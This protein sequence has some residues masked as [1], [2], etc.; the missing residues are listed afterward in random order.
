MSKILAK[1]SNPN[2]SKTT[3]PKET[4]SKEVLFNKDF[5]NPNRFLDDFLANPIKLEPEYKSI[6][7]VLESARQTIIAYEYRLEKEAEKQ[8][9]VEMLEKN[10][11]ASNERN[12]EEKYA[13]QKFKEFGIGR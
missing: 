13:A 5:N 7:N 9:K 4:F 11:I 10:K 6:L 2:N 8:E 12:A 1:N 3:T